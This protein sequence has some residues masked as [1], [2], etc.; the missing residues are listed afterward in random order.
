MAEGW[1][2]AGLV[3]DS[4]S[5]SLVNTSNVTTLISEVR[6]LACAIRISVQKATGVER[7]TRVC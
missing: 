6:H 5:A 4:R 3:D 1:R 2:I 7:D